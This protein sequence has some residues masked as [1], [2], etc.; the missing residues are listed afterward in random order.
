MFNKYI[1]DNAVKVL[2][3]NHTTGV[4]IAEI[5]IEKNGK[6]THLGIIEG[7]SLQTDSVAIY[8][9]KNSPLWKPG[10]RNGLPVRTLMRIPVRFND[11]NESPN[12]KSSNEID[13]DLTINEPYPVSEEFKE[14]DPF[15]IYTSVDQAPEFPGGKAGFDQYIKDNKKLTGKVSDTVTVSFVIEKDGS[16]K[17]FQIVT[18]LSNDCVNE[19]LRLMK[20]SPKWHQGMKNGIPVRTLSS[21]TIY[22]KTDN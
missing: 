5:L 17:Y 16:L 7:L 2:R 13:D 3:P 10:I 21:V 12:V 19:A 6:L 4:V 15:R 1:N 8:L 9:L 11:P 18:G 22:F 14:N 20:Q